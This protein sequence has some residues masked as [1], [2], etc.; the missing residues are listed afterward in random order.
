[1]RWVILMGVALCAFVAGG[2]LMSRVFEPANEEPAPPASEPGSIGGSAAADDPGAPSFAPSS[3]VVP[4]AAVPAAAAED[5]RT[6]S[7]E[8]PQALQAGLDQALRAMQAAQANGPREEARGPRRAA[9]APDPQ[10]ASGDI[11]LD[12]AG[13]G[14]EAEAL[15]KKLGPA[16]AREARESAGQKPAGTLEIEHELL[17]TWKQQ[18]EI[19]NGQGDTIDTV[20]NAAH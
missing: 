5:G 4:V 18:K 11:T 9:V 19:L 1:M 10:T 8:D 7:A 20:L 12:P 2:A 13:L 3:N 6:G 16:L 14:P 17:Q 15:A